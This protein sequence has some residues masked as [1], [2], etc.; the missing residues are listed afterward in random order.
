VSERRRLIAL[1]EGVYSVSAVCRILGPGMTARRVHYWLDTGLISGSPV[2][3]GRPGVPTLL[4]FRQ[5][6][7]IKTVQHLRDEIAVSL[8]QVRAAYAWVLRNMFDDDR[9]VTFSRGPGGALVAM[10]G[11]DEFT[12]PGGQGVLPD[13]LNV[14]VGGAYRAWTDKALSIAGYPH[15]V[16]AAGILAG[17]PTVRGTRIDTAVIASFAAPDRSADD[18]VALVVETYPRLAREAVVEALAFEGVAAV[19]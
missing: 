17:S 11:H 2:V 8:Q 9:A 19:S 10:A 15:L 13:G 16:S 4:T 5:V 1:G 7:E 12:V 3:R 18:T 6:L 14:G